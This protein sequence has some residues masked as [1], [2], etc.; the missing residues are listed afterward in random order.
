[1]DNRTKD[2]VGSIITNVMEK[3]LKRRCVTEPFKDEQVY[4]KNPFGA[5][6]VTMEVWKGAKFERSFTSCLGKAI[7]EQIAKVIAEGTGAIAHN[8]RSTLV[9]LCTHRID[10]IN[11]LLL[12]QRR[13]EIQPDWVLEVEQML[14]RTNNSFQELTV[15]SDL[16]IIRPDGKEEF[17]SF[18]TVKP[19]LDQTENAKR[20]MLHLL[21]DNPEREVYFALPYNP[22]GEG[23][24][25]IEARHNFPYKLFDM[26]NDPCVLIGS[27]LWNKIGNSPDTFSELLDIFEE[28][29]RIYS[30]RIRTEYFGIDD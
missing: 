4:L 1:M 21:A 3:I 30:P 2:S 11:E 22:G 24:P 8:Q 19:N 6:L 12:A 18:K 13:S 15:I 17:Y 16:C 27:E 5:R 7:F 10:Y 29:G 28:T 23:Q 9:R 14:T 25:Y 20:N 26:D